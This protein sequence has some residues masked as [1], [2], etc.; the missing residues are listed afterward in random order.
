MRFEHAMATVKEGLH[1]QQETLRAG[2][3]R[4]LLSLKKK[5]TLEHPLRGTAPC[6]HNGYVDPP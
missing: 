4:P 2:G 3:S 5:M 1:L 6:L